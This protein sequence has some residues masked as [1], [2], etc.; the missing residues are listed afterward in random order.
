MSTATAVDSTQTTS[1]AARKRAGSP[2]W[3]VFVLPPT[4]FLLVFVAYPTVETFR[5]SFFTPVGGHEEFAGLDKYQ[6]LL[7]SSIFWNALGNTVLLAVAFLGIVLP[8]SAV[9]A[10][11]VNRLRRG[12]APFKVIYLLPQ[13]TSSV[14]IALIFQYVFQPDWGLLNGTLRWLGVE[15]APLWLANPRLGLTG[16]RAAVTILA[17]WAGLGY[18]MLVTLAGLQSIPVEM[19]EAAALDGANGLQIWRHITLPS[20]RPTLVFLVMTGTVD[21]MSRFSD[22]WMLGGPGGAPARSL[23]TVVMYMFQTGFE[24]G[25]KNLAAAIAVVLFGLMLGVTIL[26]FRTMLSREFRD[27]RGRGRKARRG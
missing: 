12:A 7:G 6:A 21:A 19:Y 13:M 5:Q 17:V 15:S 24:S 18:Y 20:L 10:S 16:S 22:L 11:M 23:Q 1:R 14:A 9:L 3:Y 26:S 25:D 27:M 8:L 4:L 2:V